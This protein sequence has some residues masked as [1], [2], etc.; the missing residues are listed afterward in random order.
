MFF[1][2]ALVL[3]NFPFCPPELLVIYYESFRPKP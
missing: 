1:E 2:T 3:I